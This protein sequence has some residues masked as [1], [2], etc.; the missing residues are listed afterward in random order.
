MS[1][2]LQKFSK[3]DIISH[4]Y[5]VGY[6]RRM[7]NIEISSEELNRMIETPFNSGGESVILEGP[8]KKSLYKVFIDYTDDTA[9]DYYGNPTFNSITDMIDNKFEKIKRLVKYFH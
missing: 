5:E 6:M 8:T 9:Y 1:Y 4:T 7:P 3:Y 2:Y